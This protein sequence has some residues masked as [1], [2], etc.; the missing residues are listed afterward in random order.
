MNDITP[1]IDTS[2]G[3]ECSESDATTDETTDSELEDLAQSDTGMNVSVG[4]PSFEA[5]EA[6]AFQGSYFRGAE[7]TGLSGISGEIWRD[8]VEQGPSQHKLTETHPP[9]MYP[10]YFQPQFDP[11]ANY[12]PTNFMYHP[13]DN[14]TPYQYPNLAPNPFPAPSHSGPNSVASAMPIHSLDDVAAGPS[15][16][17]TVPTLDWAGVRPTKKQQKLRAV[18]SFIREELFMSPTEFLLEIIGCK[19]SD[20]EIKEY[21]SKFYSTRAIPRLLDTIS[22][23]DAQGC[24]KLDAWFETR[25]LKLVLDRVDKEMTTLTSEFVVTMKDIEPKHLLNFNI[26]SEVLQTIKDD[27]PW[28]HQILV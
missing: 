22:K 27:S 14:P 8:W 6:R 26:Q 4:S 16:E 10:Q 24:S 7:E 5:P 1:Q 3:D 19:D 11:Y 18:A 12:G 15:A 23:G 21:K 20:T 17:D 28:L 2:R 13:T 25:A 9:S